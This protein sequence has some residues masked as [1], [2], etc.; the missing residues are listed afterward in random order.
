MKM[1]HWRLLIFVLMVTFMISSIKSQT[2][3]PVTRNDIEFQTRRYRCDLDAAF[4][5]QCTC[6]MKVVKKKAGGILKG[7]G[8][9]FF[10]PITDLMV[11]GLEILIHVFFR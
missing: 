2:T 4:F 8:C 9:E 10:N 7:L 3:A 5:R 11:F 1:D 6:I